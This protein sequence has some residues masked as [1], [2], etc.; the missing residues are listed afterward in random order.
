MT[1]TKIVRCWFR[2]STCTCG[3]T[4]YA[5]P[6][7]NHGWSIDLRLERTLQ[8]SL[9]DIS[10]TS[11]CVVESLPWTAAA[12]PSVWHSQPSAIEGGREGER[13]RQR[14]GKREK[15]ISERMYDYSPTNMLIMALYTVELIHKHVYMYMYKHTSI[16]R[17]YIGMCT[18]ICMYLA[19]L[20]KCSTRNDVFIDIHAQSPR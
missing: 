2:N 4:E 15:G 19:E 18:C 9:V 16:K 7:S 13:E 11:L 8:Y 3:F 1:A 12:P 6:T 14:E 20:L 17:L 10:L 5:K